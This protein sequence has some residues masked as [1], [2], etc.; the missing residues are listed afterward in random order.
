VLPGGQGAAALTIG[1][2]AVVAVVLE[3]CGERVKACAML[4]LAVGLW[5]LDPWHVL[6]SARATVS[7]ES[8]DSGGFGSVSTDGGGDGSGDVIGGEIRLYTPQTIDDLAVEAGVVECDCS[9]LATTN[10]TQSV[11]A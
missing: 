9:F 3:W 5:L 11:T 8:K 10:V 6:S 1:A 7:A 4:V 2:L